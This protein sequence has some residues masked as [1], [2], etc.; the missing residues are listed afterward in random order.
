[1]QIYVFKYLDFL[2]YRTKKH[3]NYF[4]PKKYLYNFRDCIFFSYFHP[5]ESRDGKTICETSKLLKGMK[6]PAIYRKV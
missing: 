6:R 2:K 5:D 1:M 3:G 4:F